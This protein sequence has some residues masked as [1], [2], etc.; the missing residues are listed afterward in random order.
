VAEVSYILEHS[1]A[2]LIIVDYE[3]A[4]L[5]KDA[6]VR[7]V[8]SN[9]TGR[10]GCPYEEFLTSGRRFSHERGWGGL[11]WEADEDAPAALCYT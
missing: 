3:Y 7:V 5:V 1:G 11:D 4:H 6:K 8:V 10:S 2:R 9:D